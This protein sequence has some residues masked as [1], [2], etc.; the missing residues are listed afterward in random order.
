[1]ELPISILSK[2]L[3]KDQNKHVSLSLSSSWLSV[4]AVGPGSFFHSPLI[5][6]WAG[7]VHV[8]SSW[9]T[10]VTAHMYLPAARCTILASQSDV[11]WFVTL[12]R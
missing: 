5:F 8:I 3:M 1:M 2:I 10:N 12:N 9:D 4:V 11:M 7:A 6:S